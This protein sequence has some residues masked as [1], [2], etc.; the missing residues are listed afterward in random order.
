[1]IDSSEL[2]I[3]VLNLYTASYY[4]S[5]KKLKKEVNLTEKN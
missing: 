1:M 4:S 5:K 2:S 3:I